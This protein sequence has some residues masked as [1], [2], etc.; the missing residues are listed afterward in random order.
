MA[1]TETPT[2][3]TT[4]GI[5]PIVDFSLFLHGTPSDR[6]HTGTAIFTA[7]RDLGFVSLYPDATS[8]PSFECKES[9]DIGREDDPVTPNIWPPEDILPGFRETNVHLFTTLQKTAVE[10]LRALALGLGLEEAF[11]EKFHSEQECCNQLR[12]LHYP[13]VKEEDLRSGGTTRI[14][15]HTDKGTI[16]LL[17]QEEDGVGGLEVWDEAAGWAQAPSVKGAVLVNIGDLLM[18][19]SNDVLKSTR[20]RVVAPK[21]GGGDGWVR[22]RLSIPYFVAADR[23]AVV[24]CLETCCGPERERKYEPVKAWDYI[25][26]A[27]SPSY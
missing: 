20:H 6:L 26:K 2:T 10:V 3:T 8:A 24:E 14:A 22:R 4:S 18:M 9:F 27:M 11:F 12:L 5:V 1:A 21:E 25:V 13:A 23:D 16:T 19:W 15:E 7:F 17:L